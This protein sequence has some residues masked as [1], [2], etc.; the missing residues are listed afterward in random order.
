M[1]TMKMI[2]LVAMMVLAVSVSA[3]VKKQAKPKKT[4]EVTFTVSMTCDGCKQ[5]IEKNISWEKGVKDM[6]INVEK[7]TVKI[8][9]DPKQTSE[10]KLKKAIEKLKFTCG[11]P[12]PKIPG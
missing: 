6:E 5:K 1:K 8:N 9:Y 2:S 4:E 11:K 10:E 7:K 3:Q 12:E